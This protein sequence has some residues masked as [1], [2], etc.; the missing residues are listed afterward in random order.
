MERSSDGHPVFEADHQLVE[1]ES[2][3][4]NGHG[5]FFEDFSLC[6]R[7]FANKL[8]ILHYCFWGWIDADFILQFSGVKFGEV[9]EK[10]TFFLDHCN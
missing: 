7:D 3:V 5:P 6:P 9:Y 1:D 8:T 2:P 4:V 10:N